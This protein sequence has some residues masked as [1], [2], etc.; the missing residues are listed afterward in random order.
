VGEGRGAD[1]EG[2]AGKPTIVVLLLQR[3]SNWCTA[4]L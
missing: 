1:R 3:P 4:A 2:I